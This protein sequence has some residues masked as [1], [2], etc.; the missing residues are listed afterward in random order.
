M[1]TAII[2]VFI[3]DFGNDDD[4]PDKTLSTFKGDILFHQVGIF[5]NNVM[6]L[7]GWSLT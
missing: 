2:Y 3:S 6:K 1:G 5:R 4:L 7:L